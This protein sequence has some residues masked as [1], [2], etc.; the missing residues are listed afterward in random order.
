MNTTA[1]DFQVRAAAA[2]ARVLSASNPTETLGKSLTD[3]DAPKIVEAAKS[4]ASLV[5]ARS[6]CTTDADASAAAAATAASSSTPSSTAEPNRCTFHKTSD[7]THASLMC[8]RSLLLAINSTEIP[9]STTSSS[10]IG[11]VEQQLENDVIRVVWNGCVKKAQEDKAS[12]IKPSKALGRRSLLLAYPHVM[13][14]M[15]SGPA[16]ND[17]ASLLPAR[18]DKEEALAFFEEFGKL[19]N[20]KSDNGKNAEE[21][22]DHF[23]IW[24]TDGG[25]EELKRRRERRA[26]RGKEAAAVA[27]V[28][29]KTELASGITSAGAIDPSSSTVS[30]EELSD[31]AVAHTSGVF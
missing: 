22:D 29:A 13:K 26:K 2:T 5:A 7:P 11:G 1:D 17:D 16:G 18:V 21:I 19:L 3:S 28:Q 8:A 10:S 23:L 6:I 24:S 25:A 31:D 20:P 9:E 4:F 14:R 30:I 27:E 15:K 12:S